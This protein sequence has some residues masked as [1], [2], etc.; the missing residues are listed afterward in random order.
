MCCTIGRGEPCL[1]HPFSTKDNMVSS[2]VI[3][4]PGVLIRNG[5]IDIVHPQ[6]IVW[7]FLN[8]SRFSHIQ[9]F[10][11]FFVTFGR[12]QSLW[13]VSLSMAMVPNSMKIC[14]LHLS[15]QQWTWPS[16]LEYPDIATPSN[17]TNSFLRVKDGVEGGELAAQNIKDSIK[18]QL[19][20]TYPGENTENWQIIVW[21]ITALDGLASAYQRYLSQKS[22]YCG[23]NFRDSL[24]RFAIG[25]NRG[26]DYNFNFIDIGG[27]GD[28]KVKEITDAK[29]RETFKMSK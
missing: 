5:A 19:K 11:D 6:S 20:E 14:K 13:L 4:L 29:L 17:H 28:L 7:S 2:K 1:R 15:W 27:G 24:R 16:S 12:A 9:K 3:L 22:D 18:K 21:C 26:A 23:I 8:E 10:A 25:V